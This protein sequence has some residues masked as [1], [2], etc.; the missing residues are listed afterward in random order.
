MR[1]L[2]TGAAGFIG[3]HLCE[4]LLL[5]GDDVIGIDAFIP[6]YPRSVKERNLTSLRQHPHFT[7]HELDLREADLTAV[8]DGVE[9]I[10]HIAAMPGLLASWSRF[11]WYMTCNLQAT[12]RLLQAAC[13]SGRSPRFIHGSTSSVYGS[14]VLGNE[15]TKPQPVS[16]YGITKLA[17]EHLV[18]VYE[19][20]FGLPTSILRYF[21][22]YGPR[23]RPDMGYYLFIE[24]IL[25]ERAI[26]VF[27]DGEQLRGSTYVGDIV[28]ATQLANQRFQPGTIYNIGGTEELSAN[29]L[30][31]LLQD[32]IGKKAILQFG[33][34]RPGEQSRALADMTLARQQ[35]GFA[36][37]TPIR[38]G[39]EAQVAW[40]CDL[41]RRY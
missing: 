41:A 30:L 17:A 36:P 7:F 5:D 31:A 29:Q 39:L 32:I 9:V 40:Q 12:Q 28:R 26:T 27:G 11:D 18:Q 10:F 34:S 22:V 8:L 2:V 21:S 4:A 3:S 20:Q 37:V 33:P 15:Q 19:A 23:Q 14:H 38:Q 35:I 25:H 13:A 6:Y 16:P 1:C 24:G